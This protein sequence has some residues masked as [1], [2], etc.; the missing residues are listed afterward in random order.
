M[1][2]VFSNVNDTQKRYK[3]KNIGV[4]TCD[5]SSQKTATATRV[6]ILVS[7]K[8]ADYFDWFKQHRGE[9]IFPM[10]TS[11]RPYKSTVRIMPTSEVVTKLKPTIINT[12]FGSD[13][14]NRSAFYDECIVGL[15][16]T[17]IT[18]NGTSQTYFDY[19]GSFEAGN[20]LAGWS[21]Y[22]DRGNVSMSNFTAWRFGLGFWYCPTNDLFYIAGAYEH[23]MNDL[24]GSRNLTY[25]TEETPPYIQLYNQQ[26]LGSDKFASS[27]HT[28]IGNGATTSLA[29][30]LDVGFPEYKDESSTFKS[31]FNN[32]QSQIY[33]YFLYNA[34][35]PAPETP[36]YPTPTPQEPEGGDGNFD[37][38]SDAI[39]IDPAPAMTI[40]SIANVYEIEPANQTALHDFLWSEDFIDVFLKS[41][42][43]DP[44]S[45]LIGLQYMPI[46]PNTGAST[47]KLGNV[48]TNV[49]ARRV[50]NRIAQVDF[51]K[52]A[53]SEYWGNFLD[54]N[55]YTKVSIY[56][57]YC[58]TVSLNTDVVMRSSIGLKY[59]IDVL[60]GGV[61]GYITSN[62]NIIQTV[63]GNCAT[64]IP[65][66]VSDK[67]QM[68]TNTISGLIGGAGSIASGN[69]AGL[70]SSTASVVAG[71]KEHPEI[72]GNYAGNLG[73]LGKQGAYL[74]IERPVAS[75]PSNFAH[76]KGFRSNITRS[77]S[78]CSGFTAYD[79]I[80]LEGIP[81]TDAER[82]ELESILK[83]GI[84]A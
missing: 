17:A 73:S 74:I 64:Q 60:S 39:P 28:F 1:E 7:E 68:I 5:E 10:Q 35:Q 15:E 79:S 21:A 13:D 42:K 33:R 67:S 58:G 57:P 70:V 19:Y 77:V 80:H 16:I 8:S 44:F 48:D 43:Q 14:G 29:S 50:P 51:G 41:I 54:Y 56:C 22:Y 34:V 83:D 36:E 20:K 23:F 82:E 4:M 84:I 81:C 9:T 52:V 11:T 78:Q 59:Y 45:C 61:L 71:A 31:W 46:N 32:N 65:L 62:D 75:I 38:T 72:K 55:P 37:D 53:I 12:V 40:G 30:I 26:N 18:P 76:Q 63:S 49:S 6:N 27:T 24:S 47:V 69:I 3:F 2:I 25:F 66:S